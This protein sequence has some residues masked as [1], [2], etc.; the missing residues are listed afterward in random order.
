M[1]YLAHIFL[2]GNDK[3]IQIGNFVA[4][5]VKGN[6]YRDYPVR[7]QKGILLHRRIDTFA[8]S[9]PL[10]QELVVMGRKD[11]GRYSAVVTDVLLDHFLARDFKIYAH[12]PLKYFAYRFYWNLIWNYHHLPGR[13]QGFMWHFILTSRLECYASRE[14]IRRSLAIMV[15]YRGLKIDPDKAVDFLT[16]HEE[17]WKEL[18][19]AFFPELQAMCQRELVRDTTIILNS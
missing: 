5:A 10:V 11:F 4:D 2:S 9:H 15:K 8:D 16:V 13:F 18:F 17:E 3:Q 19:Q 6:A 12:Q 7:M 14:G 1:N